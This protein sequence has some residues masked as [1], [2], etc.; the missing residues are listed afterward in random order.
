MSKRYTIENAKGSLDQV[1][2]Y[3]LVEFPN[4][5][6]DF[7]DYNNEETMDQIPNTQDTILMKSFN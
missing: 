1:Q 4:D 3:A 6:V 7:E 2:D 5:Y